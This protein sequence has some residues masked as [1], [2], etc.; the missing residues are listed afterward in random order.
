MVMRIMKIGMVRAQ[1]CQEGV[2]VGRA[3]SERRVI[4]GPELGPGA[5]MRVRLVVGWNLAT[6]RGGWYRHCWRIGEDACRGHR[7]EKRFHGG[8]LLLISS[9]CGAV[10]GCRSGDVWSRLTSASGGEKVEASR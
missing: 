1:M 5:A 4:R 9:D 8:I 7:R 3:R 2:T 6:G 10:S